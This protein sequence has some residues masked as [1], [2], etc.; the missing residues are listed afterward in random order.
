MNQTKR[1]PNAIYDRHENRIRIWVGNDEEEKELSR[2]EYD[3]IIKELY[4]KSLKKTIGKIVL[5]HPNVV[6]DI[7]RP[8]KGAEVRKTILKNLF[9]F[10]KKPEFISVKFSKV[11]FLFEINTFIGEMFNQIFLNDQY[12]IYSSN[13]KNKIVIDAG[14]NVGIFSLYASMLGTKKYMHLNL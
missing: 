14:A 8:N 9:N 4:E 13:I 3:F 12:N 11:I 6:I 7:L 1:D 5:Q 10:K 2:Q